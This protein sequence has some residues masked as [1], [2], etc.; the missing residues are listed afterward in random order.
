MPT[1]WYLLTLI[2][3][4]MN[5]LARSVIVG[6]FTPFFIWWLEIIE[7]HILIALFGY[8]RA[9]QYYGPNAYV[10]GTIRT[11]YFHYWAAGGFALAYF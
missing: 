10:N 6:F 8:C 1:S 2:T 9:W 4:Q 5:L 7:G 11:D 3:F